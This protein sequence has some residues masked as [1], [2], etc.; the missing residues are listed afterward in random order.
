MGAAESWGTAARRAES[1]R[2]WIDAAEC[3]VRPCLG[4][5]HAR[6]SQW[7]K[8]TLP[9]A[10]CTCNWKKPEQ[11]SNESKT[12][13][14]G[15]IITFSLNAFCLHTICGHNLL[16]LIEGKGATCLNEGQLG[17]QLSHNC[18]TLQQHQDTGLSLCLPL[19]FTSFLN[20]NEWIFM[21]H[22]ELCEELHTKYLI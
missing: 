11:F 9:P 14:F 17:V 19:V 15:T 20:Y 13:A 12:F 6:L 4:R 18:L 5:V 22:P 3:C 21:Y 8:P 16:W 2:M 10:S 1:E 7:Y